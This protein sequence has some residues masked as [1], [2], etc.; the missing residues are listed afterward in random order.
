[1]TGHFLLGNGYRAFNP[2]LMRFNSPDS[3]SPFGKGGL[4]AYAYCVGDPV[5]YSDPAG[6]IAGWPLIAKSLSKIRKIPD[7]I[8]AVKPALRLDVPKAGSEPPPALKS[9]MGYS[10]NIGFHGSTVEQGD[11]LKGGLSPA[12]MNSAGGL[13]RGKGFYVAPTKQTAIDFSKVAASYTENGTPEVYRVYVDHFESMIPG[14][15]YSFGTMGEGGLVYRSLN[16]MEIVLRQKIYRRVSITALNIRKKGLVLPR[17]SEA[18][19]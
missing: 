4:N 11:S 6:H 1:M 8:F 16:E 19:F 5:N 18:P 9:N 17:A 14:V 10:D 2:V 12:F 7:K 3:L 15:H 13:S